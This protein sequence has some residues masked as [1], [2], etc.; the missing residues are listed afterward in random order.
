MNSRERVLAALDHKKTDRVPLDIG[1]INNSTM[2]ATIEKELKKKLG[3]KDNGTNIMAVNQGVV[4]P[5]ESVLEHFGCDTRCVYMNE[6]R[7]WRYD[8]SK[9]VYYDQWN[10]G[11]K[12]NPD[13][14]YYNNFEHPLAAAAEPSDLDAYEFFEPNEEI[15]KGLEDRIAKFQGDYCLVLEG[16]REPMFG[17][18]SWLRGTEN[19]YC[20]LVSEDGMADALLDKILSHYIKWTSY[21]LDRVGS[22]I[23]VLKVADDMGTQ[24]SLL[25][26]PDTYRKYIKPR[27]AALYGHMKKKCPKAKLLLHACG[28]VRPILGDL[29]E[30]GVDAINPVQISAAGMEPRELKA[31]FG[32]KLTF[33]GGG[34]DTQHTL[35]FS[36]PAEVK[37]EVRKNMAVFKENGGFVFTQVHNIMPGVPVDNVIAMYEAYAENASY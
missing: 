13:G 15:V 20:D 9:D 29:I 12:M 14:F 25:L 4:V 37:R 21:V 7:P 28:A 22:K 34:V 8:A 5:D 30:I 19:F 31:E 10:I 24:S 3:L 17:L 27:Q 6:A 32:Q 35:Q 18:P 26:S 1:G 16:F 36:T 33:W 11:L 2:H 23:D